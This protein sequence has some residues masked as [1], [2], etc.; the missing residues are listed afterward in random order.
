MTPAA[1]AE[2]AAGD[3]GMMHYFDVGIGIERVALEKSGPRAWVFL[4]S[5]GTLHNPL[6][7]VFTS[8]ADGSKAD[9]LLLQ[10]GSEASGPFDTY[11]VRFRDHPYV[12]TRSVG[13]KGSYLDVYR[14]G[15]GDIICSFRPRQ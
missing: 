11:F 12:V 1:W 9:R 2:G 8:T 3:Y 15:P 10:L 13:E 6:F 14:L 4:T 5:V 7:W